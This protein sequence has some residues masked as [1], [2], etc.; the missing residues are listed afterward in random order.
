MD[1]TRR[2]RFRHLQL[3]ISLA[4][5]GSLSDTA[6]QAHTTQPGLSKWLKELEEDAGASLF[7]RHARGLTP[8]PTGELLVSHARRIQTEMERA[9]LN[10]EALQEGSNRTFA[11]GTSPAAAPSFVPAAMMKFLR[12]HPKTRLQLQENTMNAMLEQ[13]EHGSLDVVVG[14]LDNFEPRPSLRTEALYDEPLRIIARVEHPLSY[15]RNISWDQVLKYDW[16]VWPR[17]TPIRSRLENALTAA[18]LHRPHYRI[19]STSQVGNLWLLQYSD[20]LSVASERIAR[21][22]TDRGLVVPLDI[23]L[24]SEGGF[25][26]MCWRD[27]ANPDAALQ[28]LLDCFRQAVSLMFD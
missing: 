22:F 26:G 7:E 3:L 12:Q 25:V 16:V 11:V 17:G 5:T 1:W 28:D 2:L 20:M 4:E 9:Q 27:E 10:L 13:L 15:E 21:H 14:R 6:R 19:E 23:E 24:G 8:T 18:G